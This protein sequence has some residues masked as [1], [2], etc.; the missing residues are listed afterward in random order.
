MFN[1]PEYHI[2]LG[3]MEIINDPLVKKCDI[4]V[5]PISLVFLMI[6]DCS[7]EIYS[8]GHLLFINRQTGTL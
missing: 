4:K 8:S 5:Y 1:A 2:P 3:I 7:A 6:Q